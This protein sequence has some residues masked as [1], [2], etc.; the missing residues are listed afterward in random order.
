MWADYFQQQLFLFWCFQ[1]KL[2]YFVVKQQGRM[3]ENCIL[4]LGETDM[5]ASFPHLLVVLAQV[6]FFH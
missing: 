3:D 1:Q 4:F 2:Q 6:E 5:I